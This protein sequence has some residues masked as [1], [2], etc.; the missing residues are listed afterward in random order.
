MP[1]LINL[2]FIFTPASL[3]IEYCAWEQ[4]K[5]SG[6]ETPPSRAQHVALSTPENDHV[7]I[8]GGHANPTTRLN[9]TWWLKVADLTWK[10]AEG[11][12]AVESNQESKIGAPPPRAN[13]GSCFYKGRY[14]IY[15]GHGG[16]SYARVAFSDIYT[17]DIETNV[18][19]KIEAVQGQAPLP[20]GRGGHSIFIVDDKLYSYGGWNSETMFNNVIVFDLNTKEWSDPDIYNDAQR[21]NHSAIMVEAIPSWKYFIF[22]GEITNYHEGHP[23]TFG[24]CDNTSYYL[25]IET[26]KWT[27][28]V[29]E[30]DIRPP[31][32]EYAAMA[33]DSDQ[34]RLLVFGGWNSGWLQDMFALNVSKIVGP[35]YAIT[36]IDPPLS[37][38]S[39]AVPVVIKG[40]G[41]KDVTI[42]V[43]FTCGKNP[44]D[45]P[46]KQSIYTSGV[47]ISETEIHALT[48]NFKDF[49]PKEAV[50]QLMIATG[51]LTTTWVPFSFFLNTRANKSLCHG[52]GLFQDQAVGAPIEFIIQA[53]NDQNENRKSGRDDFQVKIVTKGDVPREIAAE[54][55]DHNDGQYYVKYQVEE[56]CE[57]QISVLFKDE[58]GSMVPV[59]GSP[60]SASFNA[61]TNANANNLTGPVMTKHITKQI[62]NLQSFM[63]DTAAGASTKDKDFADVKTLIE[64][65]D[66]YELVFN[67]KD[68]VTLQLDQLE[69]SLKLLQQNGIAKD[70]QIKASKRLFDEFVTLNKL[71][72][73]TKQE[74][75]KDISQEMSKN[76]SSIQKLEEEL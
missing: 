61:N 13:C 44:T 52:T 40:C 37:Q 72:R 74:I 6:D 3:L 25:D 64:V 59:R 48:P 58:S 29:P 14:Y 73:T 42:K 69:E 32:R 75:A 47:F 12:N 67:T 34:S 55:D 39:G 17:F 22:G 45:V 41:F 20:E 10:R 24:E 70:S 18:W 31:C 49:G 9:D 21:W 2:N 65:K 28:I 76:N 53:R 1:A 7:F 68:S 30:D 56:E 57:V 11:D 62:E 51:D 19:E 43:Y 16:R 27:A 26:M 63:K 66:H 71:A 15:G 23:R 4:E 35:S 5:G 60:Y 46:N 36:E 50:V 38:L 8:F 33:Y 54:I